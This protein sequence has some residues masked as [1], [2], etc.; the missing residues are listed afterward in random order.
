MKVLDKYILKQ[1]VVNFLFGVILFVVLVSAGDLLFRLARLWWQEGFSL[2]EVVKIF[3]LS[4][5]SLLIYILPVSVLLSVLLTVGRMSSDSEIIALRAGGVSFRRLTVPFFLF[6][7]W[8][9][10]GTIIVQEVCLP[11]ASVELKEIGK[12]VSG[13][14][15]M[16]E[17]TFFRDESEPGIERVFYVKTVDRE[18]S[19]LLGVVVQEYD[20]EGLRRIINAQEASNEGG[21]WIFQEGTIYQ[22]GEEGEIERVVRFEKEEVATAQSIEEIQKTQKNPQEMSF[23]ELKNFIEGEKSRGRRTEQLELILWQKTAFPFASLVFVLI[24]ISLGI[25]SPRSG[26]ALGVGLSVLIVFAYYVVLSLGS[27]L[28]EGGSLSPFWGTWMANIMGFATGGGLLWWK[29]KN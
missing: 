29:E 5:P 26:R 3:F 6:S 4:L 12:R 11:W 18:K 9:C 22:M 1:S 25:V 21:K 19:L 17:N 10:A 13:G 2:G 15:L 20:E 16:P 23:L 28:A 24:G 27:A 7:L 14:E 8:V